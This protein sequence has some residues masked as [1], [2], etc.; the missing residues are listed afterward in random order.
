MGAFSGCEK[1]RKIVIPQTVETIE[2]NAFLGCIDLL[3]VYNLSELVLRKGS[4]ENGFVAYYALAVYSSLD[5]ESLIEQK[6]DF[7]FMRAQSEGE[8]NHLIIYRGEEREVVLPDDLNGEPYVIRD[9]V[10]S[11]DMNVR[12]ITVPNNVTAIGAEVFHNCTELTSFIGGDGVTS[13]GDKAFYGCERLS[14]ITLP[15]GLK[16]LGANVFALCKQ[17]K[18]VVLSDNLTEIKEG[19]F[20][21]SGLVSITLPAKLT[22]IGA[23]AFEGCQKLVTDLPQSVTYLGEK[24]FFNCWSLNE[25]TIPDGVSIIPDYAFAYGGLKTLVVGSVTEIGAEAFTGCSELSSVTL[26]EGVKVIKTGAFRDCGSLT[27]LHFPASFETLYYSTYAEDMGSIISGCRSLKTLTVDGANAEFFSKNNCVIDKEA[28]AIVLGCAGSVIPADGSVTSIMSCAFYESGITS[29][30][31]PA[32]I[33]SIGEDVFR[34][35]YLQSVVLQSAPDMGYNV[36][37]YC[38]AL[39]DVTL[40]AGTE[41]LDKR[42]FYYCSSLENIVL[43]QGLKR[44]GYKAFEKTGLTSLT[45]PEGVTDIDSDAFYGCLRLKEVSLPSTLDFL[46][47]RAFGNSVALNTVRYNGTYIQWKKIRTSGMDWL[48]G[49]AML[50]CKGSLFPVKLKGTDN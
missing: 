40:A 20:K 41:T 44:I 37:A 28:S 11:G 32:Q 10:F 4:K 31:I 13:I 18:T 30:T 49:E 48:S 6:G 19:V 8:K 34:G 27:S 39:R 50:Y 16:S 24:C 5:D 2:Q 33:K 25:I 7:V 17:L 38:G 14:E 9:R 15:Q 47:C 22:K 46:G 35:S 23:S 45:V 26:G 29:V 12:V 36:F 21:E 1:L 42:I 43:P 3:E